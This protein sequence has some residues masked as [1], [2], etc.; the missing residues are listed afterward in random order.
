[1]TLYV[2]SKAVDAHYKDLTEHL[3]L[4]IF[5]LVSEI[6]IKWE[7]DK[8]AAVLSYSSLFNRIFITSTTMKD[9]GYKRY[10]PYLNV[11]AELNLKLGQLEFDKI[12][13]IKNPI[14]L[15]P[16]IFRG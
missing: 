12:P 10:L 4:R 16:K 14:N 15:L 1:M 5:K 13:K 8:L 2:V 7:G 3:V 9:N 11:K 6:D